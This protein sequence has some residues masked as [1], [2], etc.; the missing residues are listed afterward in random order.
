M[1]TASVVDTN[2]LANEQSKTNAN[3][4]E[5]G[6]SVLLGCQ[7]ENREDKLSGQEHLDE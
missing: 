4:C 6:G 3:R 1:L 7:H 5:E 2:H